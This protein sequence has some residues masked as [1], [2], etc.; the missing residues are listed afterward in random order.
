MLNYYDYIGVSGEVSLENGKCGNQN[1]AQ[2]S[3]AVRSSFDKRKSTFRTTSRGLIYS[4]SSRS[5]DM[6]LGTDAFLSSR[7]HLHKDQTLL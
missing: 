3:R 2:N 5:V 7:R 6:L 4:V 1:R